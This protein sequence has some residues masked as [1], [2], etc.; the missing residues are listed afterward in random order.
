MGSEPLWDT[1][2][3]VLDG[4]TLDV[5]GVVSRVRFNGVLGCETLEIGAHWD[6][7]GS[8]SA[9]SGYLMSENFVVSKAPTY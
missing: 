9:H 5:G 3:K 8:S 6:D 7:C 2:A 4:E 1:F